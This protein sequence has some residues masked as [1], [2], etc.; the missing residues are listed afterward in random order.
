VLV[1]FAF[2]RRSLAGHWFKNIFRFSKSQFME[3]ELDFEMKFWIGLGFENVES[4]HLW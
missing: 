2:S 1:Y 4:V 3:F